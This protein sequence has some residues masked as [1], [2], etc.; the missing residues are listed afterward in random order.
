MV[1]RGFKADKDVP[2]H[3]RR[4]RV[5]ANGGRPFQVTILDIDAKHGNGSLVVHK[6]YGDDDIDDGDYDDVFAEKKCTYSSVAMPRTKFLKVWI[7]RDKS[8]WNVYAGLEKNVGNTALV[9]VS[10]TKYVLIGECILEFSLPSHDPV[11]EY[12][13]PVTKGNDVP[14]PFALTR[15]SAIS[16]DGC[17]HVVRIPLG[18]LPK[19]TRHPYDF[20]AGSHIY[21]N[22]D[23]ST[24]KFV[25]EEP[26]RRP[27]PALPRK[28]YY[29]VPGWVSA[30]QDK[31]YR[32]VNERFGIPGVRVLHKRLD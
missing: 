13:S 28:R 23:K 27:D 6:C 15:S 14:Y 5:H 32:G 9:Q 22:A 17:E 11:V 7:G 1:A 10:E 19:G 4:F 30:A 20:H 8:V 18:A 25:W 3:L 16:F 29:Y 31:H 21:R 12:A 2:K 24:W 26:M